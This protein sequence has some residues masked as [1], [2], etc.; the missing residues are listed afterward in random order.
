M[1]KRLIKHFQN[2][3]NNYIDST[4]SLNVVYLNDFLSMIT[5][6]VVLDHQVV[7]VYM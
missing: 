7:L 3:N 4:N 6:N 5:V 1:K 2:N